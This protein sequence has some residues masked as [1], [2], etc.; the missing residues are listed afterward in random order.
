LAAA[1]YRVVAP[2]TRGYSP[3]GFAEDG[4]YS[5][6]ALGADAIALGQAN[7]VLCGGTE[8]MS[9]TPH[10]LEGSRRGKKLGDAKLTDYLLCGLSDMLLSKHMGQLVESLSKK[11]NVDRAAQDAYAVRSSM[12]CR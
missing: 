10:G 7:V 6:R 12:M 9:T 1:G 5:V 3:T 11:Y 2:F 8:S 4:D